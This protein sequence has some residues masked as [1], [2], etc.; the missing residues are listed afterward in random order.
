MSEL[1][2]GRA[3]QYASQFESAQDHF[4]ALVASLTPE[5]WHR[6]GKNHPQRMNEEDEGRTVGVIAHHV[7]D[8]ETFI[9]ARITSML[10]GKPLEPVDFKS[11]NAAH[12]IRHANVTRDEVI[13]KLKENKSR[14]ARAVAAIPEEQLDLMRDTPVGPMSIAQR[15][16]RVLIGHLTTHQGSIEAALG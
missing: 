7:A 11:T 9:M 1:S 3:A 14:I 13:Q 16:E 8:A 15:L 5:Q 4:I 10:E 12:A 2:T 6:V